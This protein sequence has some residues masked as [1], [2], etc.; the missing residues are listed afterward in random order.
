[1]KKQKISHIQFS[2]NLTI[3]SNLSRYKYIY[4]DKFLYIK[5]CLM[6]IFYKWDLKNPLSDGEFILRQRQWCRRLQEAWVLHKS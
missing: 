1:M 2:E 3:P 4:C 6:K 5:K